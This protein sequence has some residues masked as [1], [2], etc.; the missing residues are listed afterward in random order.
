ML[1]FWLV[2]TILIDITLIF[3][4]PF[5]LH[6]LESCRLCILYIPVVSC[7]C[8]FVWALD[9]CARKCRE[10]IKLLLVVCL[11]F[12]PGSP[13]QLHNL[14]GTCCPLLPFCHLHLCVIF[15]IINYTSSAIPETFSLFNHS[16]PRPG[17]NTI[18]LLAT[19]GSLQR[20][21][22]VSW[23]KRHWLHHLLHSFPAPT[24]ILPT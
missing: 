1:N 5:H 14:C 10:I 23:D 2:V 12:W 19:C 13:L 8:H 16:D 4:F 18:Q 9:V 6:L 11:M 7:N 22:T 21:L 24:L 3:V 17:H 15:Y 20:S